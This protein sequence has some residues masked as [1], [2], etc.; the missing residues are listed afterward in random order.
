MFKVNNNFIVD[1]EHISHLALVFLLLTLSRWMPT[2]EKLKRRQSSLILNLINFEIWKN[3][4]FY[5]WFWICSSL[6]RYIFTQIFTPKYLIQN[7]KNTATLW[8]T[9]F[10]WGINAWLS[11]FLKI[12]FF[13]C[14]CGKLFCVNKILYCPE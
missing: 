7:I 10:P 5:C 13:V 1:F 12:S 11:T 2:W 6:L 9:Y 14:K 3:Y 8:L 4:C